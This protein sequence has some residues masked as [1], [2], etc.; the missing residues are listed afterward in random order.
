VPNRVRTKNPRITLY[1][2]QAGCSWLNLVECFFSVITRPRGSFTSVKELVNTIG[3]FIDHW[4][5]HPVPFT[6]TKDADD[7]RLD[8]SREDLK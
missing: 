3:Q 1:F 5:D 6:W 7:P 8:Q 2:T 4:N